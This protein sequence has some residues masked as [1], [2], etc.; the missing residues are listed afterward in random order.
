MKYLIDY[1]T[2]PLHIWITP[3]WFE[4]VLQIVKKPLLEI[5][6]NHKIHCLGIV[7]TKKNICSYTI[8]KY[9]RKISYLQ[10]N[11]SWYSHWNLPNMFKYC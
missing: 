11:N 4:F 5:I 3:I 8:E 2:I 6:E 9:N 7:E 1:K 10:K